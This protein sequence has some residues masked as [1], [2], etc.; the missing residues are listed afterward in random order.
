MGLSIFEFEKST[1]LADGPSR[2]LA[3]RQVHAMKGLMQHDHPLTLQR[4]LRRMRTYH[5]RSR[6]ITVSQSAGPTQTTFE[7]IVSRVDRLCQALKQLGVEP[8]DRV[9]TLAWNSR[10]HLELYLAVPCM[11]AIIHTLNPRLFSEQLA[12]VIDHAEDRVIFVDDSLVPILAPLLARLKSVRACVVIGDGEASSLEGA[13]RY[14]DLLTAQEPRE[15]DYPLISDTSAASLCYTTGTT[16]NPKG[17]LYSHRS[18][19]MHSMA[20]CMPDVT[21]IHNADRVLQ[22]APMFHVNGWGL[23]YAA[24]MVG[25][26]LIMLGHST[27]PEL[28]AQVVAQQ[29]VTFTAAIP[30]VC[31]ELLRYADTERPDLSSLRMIWCGGAPV[32]SF[33]IEGFEKRHRVQVIQGWGMTETS[34]LALVARP[35]S[36]IKGDDQ[37]RYRSAAGRPHPLID[38]RIVGDDRTEL[39]W[40]GK[41][42]GELQ[43]RGPWVASAYFR[44]KGADEK[45]D[46]GWLKTGD[47]ATID[48]EGYVRIVDRVKDLIKSGGEWISSVELEGQLMTHPDV[49]E[50]AVIGRPDARWDERPLACIVLKST[51]S[52]TGADLARYL[53]GRVAKWW[54]PEQFAFVD[55]IPKTSVGKFDK[56]LLR[57]LLK[58]GKLVG[59]PW[60]QS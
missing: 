8:G 32:P 4:V 49:L 7:S 19:V 55:S 11:G 5:A 24:T 50:A 14:E 13:N 21:G 41:S 3:Q 6:F 57:A 16:G 37:W 17:V 47:V 59:V 58:E 48:G 44:D 1:T 39:P 23:P 35:P 9:A 36:G 29:Q 52:D 20:V 18:L 46:G 42:I 54:I 60:S 56:K 34:P 30:T 40:D 12:Y 28:I 2:Q 33:L 31:A 25:A 27:Q 45:F 26:D 38:V 10:E 53:S 43:V 15:F 22:I 51:S